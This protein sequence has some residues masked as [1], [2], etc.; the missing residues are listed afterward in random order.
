VVSP[1]DRSRRYSSPR[2]V[3]QDQERRL[4]ASL[5]TSLRTV[6]R[7][8]SPAP[9]V[10]AGYTVPPAPAVCA[11]YT[12]P[13]ALWD[14]T[15]RWVGS[16]CSLGHNEAMSLC[17]SFCP[18]TTRRWLLLL[19]LPGYN[20]AMTAPAAP[21]GYTEVSSPVNVVIPAPRCHRLLMLVIPAPRLPG[22][23]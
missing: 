13:P 12:V 10:C 5:C 8:T 3:S 20:E 18:G 1:T 14:I 17:S 4:I 2:Y 19:L 15:R 21:G 11:G 7:C 23:T 9:A 16:F 6:S 22:S